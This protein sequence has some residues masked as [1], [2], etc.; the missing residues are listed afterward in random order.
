L[1]EGKAMLDIT[2]GLSRRDFVRV[3]AAGIAGLTFDRWLGLKAQ[4]AVQEGTAKSVIQLWMGGGPPHL[5]TWDPKPDAGD[6]YTGPLKKPIET[7]VK[8]IRIAETMP[9]MAKQMDKYAILRGMTHGHDGHETATYMMMTGT[10]PSAELPYPSIGSVVAMKKGYEAGYKGPLPPFIMIPHSLG[11]FT[12]AG[13]LGTNYKPFS[14]GGDPNAKEFRVGGLF[15]ARGM[16]PE[17]MEERRSLVEAVDELARRAEKDEELRKMDSYKEKA[18]GLILG[19]AKKAF[20]LSQEKDELRDKYGRHRF[21]QSCLLARRLVENGVPF[22][23]VNWGGW[24]THSK[25]FES[26][27]KMLPQLDQGF[28]T[29]LEDMAQRGLMETTIVTWFGEFGRTPKVANEPPWQ[30]GRHHYGK[31]F[32]AVVAG[33][34]FKGGQIVGSTDFRGETVRERPVYPWDLSA[35]IYKL[36][37]INPQGRLPHPQGCV[38]YVAPQGGAGYQS[39]GM[40]TEIM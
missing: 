7:N 10:L 14:T 2:N 16:T 12:E 27:Q 36:L 22:V 34:G 13:F 15:P 38:A 24:D 18:Y 23:T 17:R 29:L 4:G 40:L 35:S 25:H 11:R 5:D 26:M 9:L 19:D 28:A 37:G 33:G 20:D 32:S 31:A 30:G 1:K 3:G 39:G 8:G 21:G 6:E